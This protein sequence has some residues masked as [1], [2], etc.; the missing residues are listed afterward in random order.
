MFTRIAEAPEEDD[1]L[2][3]GALCRPGDGVG[4]EAVSA[5]E[6]LDPQGVNK[7]CR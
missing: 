4:G 5:R 1:L 3:A 2:H 7:I 6:I